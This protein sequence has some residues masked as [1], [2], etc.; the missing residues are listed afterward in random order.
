LSTKYGN[1]DS[2]LADAPSVE[3]HAGEALPPLKPPP[4]RTPAPPPPRPPPPPPPPVAAPRPPVP[5]KVGRAPPV[6][7][8]KGKLKPSPLGPH[9]ENPSEGDDLDSEEAPKAKL[10]PFFWDKVVANPDHSMVWDEISS[11]SFQ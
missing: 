7:P 4:G 9:R 8:S 5:P 3:A 1:H 2:S 10:K 11:G 6:P